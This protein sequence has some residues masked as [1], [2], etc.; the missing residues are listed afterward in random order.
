M[1]QVT[2]HTDGSALGNPGPGGYGA[3]LDYRGHLRELSQG[4]ALTTNNRME[5]RAAIAAL[6]ALK[7][8]CAVALHSDSQYVVNAMSLG[9]LQ[10]WK[11]NGW[12]RGPKKEPLLNADLWKRLDQAAA[13]HRVDWIWLRGHAGDERNERCDQIAKAA[14]TAENLEPDHGYASADAATLL[15]GENCA[16]GNA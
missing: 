2:I 12:A 8:P 1:K 11:R 10:N 3:I 5:L 13:R 7:E 6:E 9:W 15:G 14:A 16:A 4:F